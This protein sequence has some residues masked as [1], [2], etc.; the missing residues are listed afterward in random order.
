MGPEPHLIRHS[1]R[2]TAPITLK[3]LEVR[4]RDKVGYDGID[5]LMGMGV[6]K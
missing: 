1:C 6:M 3:N 4:Q 5:M 2:C